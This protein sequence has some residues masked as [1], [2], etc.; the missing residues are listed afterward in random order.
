MTPLHR[1]TAI[2]EADGCARR[3]AT[4]AVAL[5]PDTH[6]KLWASNPTADGED[7]TAP[8]WEARRGAVGVL[9]GERRG[10]LRASIV[11][12]ALAT[13]LVALPD[14]LARSLALCSA[15]EDLAGE[16]LGLV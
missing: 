11:D 3:E 9:P 12:V 6:W 5:Q 7:L 1:A 13:F 10:D 16:A 14:C 8:E 4:C 2:A 15:S